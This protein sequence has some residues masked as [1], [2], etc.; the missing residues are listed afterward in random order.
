MPIENEPQGVGGPRHEILQRIAIGE[1]KQVRGRPPN[2]KQARRLRLNLIERSPLPGSI[3]EV[4]Q[5]IER[6]ALD[7]RFL[8]NCLSG[9]HATCHGTGIDSRR[10]PAAADSSRCFTRLPR[11]KLGQRKLGSATE[12]WRIYSF[13]VTVANENDFCHRMALCMGSFAREIADFA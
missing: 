4:V 3:M 2:G 1:S 12:A 6:L 7:A 5:V 11:S 9:G 10:S 13:D 8:R